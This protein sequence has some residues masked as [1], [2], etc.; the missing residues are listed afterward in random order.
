MNLTDHNDDICDVLS[1][2]DAGERLGVA[3]PAHLREKLDRLA[4]AGSGKMKVALV[5]GFSEGKTSL[6][7]AWLGMLPDDMKISQGESSNAVTV[8]HTGDD[9]ELVDTPGLFGF[10]EANIGDGA[11]EKYKEMTRK[12]VSEANLLLYVLNPSNPLKESHR[13]ELNWLFR[14]LD[15]LPRTV[16]VI[17]RFDMVADVEDDADYDHNLNIKRNNIRSRLRD[18]IGLTDDEEDALSIVGV[19][20]NPFD[21]GIASWLQ[22]PDEYARLSHIEDLRAATAEKIEAVGG[23]DEAKRQTCAIILR[24]V[25]QRVL[26]PAREAADTAERVAALADREAQQEQPRLARYQREAVEA[27][28]ALRTM[29]VDYF[30]DLIIETKNTDMAGFS[31]FFDRKIGAEGSVVGAM[32]TNAFTRELGPISQQLV[33]MSA[34]FVS[35]R[36]GT[37]AVTSVIGAAVGKLKGSGAINN[38]TILKARDWVMPAFKFKPYGAIKAAKFANGAVGII[39]VGVELWS[40]WSENRKKEEFE[41]ARQAIADDLSEQRSTILKQIDAPDFLLT[42]FPQIDALHKLFSA[43]AAAFAE[44]SEHSRRT[45]E[46]TNLGEALHLRLTGEPGL[47]SGNGLVIDV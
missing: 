3:I 27:Q 45:R 41:R 37:K 23:S 24:D 19:S 10:K 29:V 42:H 28:S 7:A 43:L 40:V 21:E 13:E 18:L 39:G 38:S 34:D 22:R 30:G 31:E 26:V 11:A 14:D 47:L 32:I 15:L 33:T 36:S 44:A 25:A 9:V 46:W 17:G 35:D 5:G 20:A 12:Y 4:T 6:A 16:F 1:F 8:Y 2:L